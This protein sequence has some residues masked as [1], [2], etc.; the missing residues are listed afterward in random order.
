MAA[1]DVD[2]AGLSTTP[3]RERPELIRTLLDRAMDEAAVRDHLARALAWRDA[4]LTLEEVAAGVA[5][6]FRGRRVQGYP[7]SLW[8]LLEHIRITQSDLL[9]FCRNADYEELRW[10]EEYWPLNPEP[11]DADAWEWSLARI[12]EDRDALAELARDASVELTATIPHGNGQTYL[13]ELLLAVDHTA[14][15]LGQMVAL[16]R[17]LGIWS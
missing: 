12:R 17:L 6:E 3:E 5:P 10:P 13:R 15:H 9:D 14:Y 8:E 16:R 2:V 4:H 7:H 11:P 1:S